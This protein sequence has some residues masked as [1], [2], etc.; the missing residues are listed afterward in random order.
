LILFKAIAVVLA[1]EIVTS[2][3]SP[4]IY[5][6]A[7]SCFLLAPL[8]A[9]KQYL[10]VALPPLCSRLADEHHW[11]KR[12]AC[13]WT[14]S[15]LIR[16]GILLFAGP[17]DIG[18]VDAWVSVPLFLKR[19]IAD[20]GYVGLMTKKSL[21]YSALTRGSRRIYPFVEDI[22]WDD[23]CAISARSELVCKVRQYGIRTGDKEPT[24]F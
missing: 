18:G 10:D 9:L 5:L 2:M 20:R 19:K 7:V 1:L 15:E 17:L 6:I 11:R 21:V 22:R 16:R 14:L 8:E 24:V 13:D 12:L 23:V 4:E 3:S